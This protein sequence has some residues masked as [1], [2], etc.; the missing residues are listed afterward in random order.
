M[1]VYESFKGENNKSGLDLLIEFINKNKI[2]VI[3][4][5]YLGG[6]WILIYRKS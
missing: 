5:N 1:V 4:I 3:S 2:E 6:E